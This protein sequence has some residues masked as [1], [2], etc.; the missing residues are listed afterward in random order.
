MYAIYIFIICHCCGETCILCF[1]NQ[2]FHCSYMHFIIP[3]KTPLISPAKILTR[4]MLC[5]HGIY[6]CFS[7]FLGHTFKL[8]K[9]AC[10][11]SLKC[12]IHHNISCGFS[13]KFGIY[14]FGVVLS[15]R[16]HWNGLLIWHKC[17]AKPRCALSCHKCSWK[18]EQSMCSGYILFSKWVKSS[19]FDKPS[20]G[21][22]LKWMLIIWAEKMNDCHALW[23]FRVLEANMRTETTVKADELVQYQNVSCC[24]PVLL[25]PGIV[26]FVCLKNKNWNSSYI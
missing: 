6:L 1:L 10:Y 16:E 4:A 14:L 26:E 25:F 22:S 24:T 7:Q 23:K 21:A 8:S 12:Q 5:F 13:L 11:C 20:Y 2:C 17:Q 3:A 19:K 9:L 18:R 15:C